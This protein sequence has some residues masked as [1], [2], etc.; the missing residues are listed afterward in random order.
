MCKLKEYSC[1]VRCTRSLHTVV[2]E[3]RCWQITT[4]TGAE[5]TKTSITLEAAVILT[6]YVGNTERNL[7][8]FPHGGMV[9]ETQTVAVLA[10]TVKWLSLLWIILWKYYEWVVQ[11]AAPFMM[12]IGN[13]KYAVMFVVIL[14]IVQFYHHLITN[15]PV[16]LTVV[17]F[18]RF[19]RPH[20]IS[21]H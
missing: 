16:T 4:L 9:V 15:R 1:R 21:V 12:L 20:L 18:A 10:K 8:E 5:R 6:H 19:L 17:V 2:E 13:L 11:T 14:R 7:R 3:P